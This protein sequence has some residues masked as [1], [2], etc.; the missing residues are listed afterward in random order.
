MNELGHDE[1]MATDGDLQG[2]VRM[3]ATGTSTLADL[4]HLLQLLEVMVRVTLDGS[5]HRLTHCRLSSSSTPRSSFHTSYASSETAEPFTE[6]ADALP[7]T[8]FTITQTSYAFTATAD[9]LTR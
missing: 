7:K 4:P 3:R 5:I 1:T 9:P 6:T 2:E 8:T